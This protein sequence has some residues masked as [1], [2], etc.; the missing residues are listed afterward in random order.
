MSE[1]MEGYTVIR[2]YS[3]SSLPQK[4][5]CPFV[6][7]FISLYHMQMRMRRAKDT[8]NTSENGNNFSLSKLST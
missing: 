4:K 5:G 1:L 2:F 6:S 3:I 8:S 7:W